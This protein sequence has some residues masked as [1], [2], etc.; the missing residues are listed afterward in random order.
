MGSGG[1]MLLLP[2]REG[3]PTQQ[4]LLLIGRSEFR[5]FPCGLR[6]RQPG[7]TRAHQLFD[8]RQNGVERH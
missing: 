2:G 6:G 4:N 5:L 1:S 7:A 8:L 3:E